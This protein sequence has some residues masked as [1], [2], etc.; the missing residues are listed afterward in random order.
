PG[1]R[2]GGGPSVLGK[3]VERIERDR[4]TLTVPR[5]PHLPWGY[6]LPQLRA[7]HVASA[8]C[9]TVITAGKS[10]RSSR[11]TGSVQLLPSA[12]GRPSLP[13]SCQGFMPRQRICVM[14]SD[15]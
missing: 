15:T 12:A 14:R 7:G 1:L 5:L 13:V 8:P 3:V 11:L 10:D 9:A 6:A 2:S 4:R